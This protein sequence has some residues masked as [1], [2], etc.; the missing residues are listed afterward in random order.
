MHQTSSRPA[1]AETRMSS[2]L[3]VFVLAALALIVLG[4]TV[5]DRD[6]LGRSLPVSLA[7]GA[8]FGLVLQRGRF[9]FWCIW[10]DWLALRDPGGLIAIL[11]ALATG[12]TG[13][14]LVFAVWVPDPSS[15]RLP[16]DAHVGPV[17]L[18]LAAGAFSFGLG[19]AISGSCISAHFYRLGEGAF[20]SLVALA[21]ASVGFI[22]G[23]LSWNTL[24]LADL[25]RAPVIW[26]PKWLGHSGALAVTL[27]VLAGLAFPLLRAPLPQPVPATTAREAVLGRRWPAVLT[28]TLIGWIAVLAYFRV[29]P[30]GVTAELGSL[31]R[32]A[33]STAGW[34]PQT[35]L[36]LDGFAGCATLVKETLLSRNGVFV[37]GMILAATLSATLAG[38]WKPGLPPLRDLPRLFAGGLMLG[39]G[40]MVSLGCTV[41]VLLSGIMAGAVSGWV[42]A[43]FCLAGAWAGWRLRGGRRVVP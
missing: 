5:P 24:Y 33:A 31:A 43:A 28:G 18:T 29:G 11:T 36:G 3:P 9:C 34:L 26:L 30:L 20:G 4:L 23:F 6:P 15:G 1:V 17:S 38:D 27:A 37:I 35:L 40:A 41:G 7:L 8:A 39:W 42:F 16:P 13:Y 19:M 12:A 25:Y 21:G 2:R 14:A 32:T 10:R 22:L